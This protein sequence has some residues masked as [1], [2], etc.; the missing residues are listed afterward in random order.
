MK[1][2]NPLVIDN[3]DVEQGEYKETP[4]TEA[5]IALEDFLDKAK[6]VGATAKLTINKLSNGVNSSETFCSSYPVDKYDYFELLDVIQRSWGGGDY[7]I[8]CTVKG[9]KGVL[10]NQFISVG[11]PPIR[12]GHAQATGESGNVLQTVIK[13]MQENNERLIEALKP[14]E[15]TDAMNKALQQMLL[16]K[17]VLGNGGQKQSMLSSVKE[18]AEVMTL[19]QG[20][21][22][23]VEKESMLTSALNAFA[24]VAVAALQRPQA[25]QVRQYAQPRPVKTVNTPPQKPAPEPK[26]EVNPMDEHAAAIKQIITVLDTLGENGVA[27]SA[28]A[29][30]ITESIDTQEKFDALE[31]W[32]INPTCI[33][34][35]VKLDKNVERYQSWFLL[36]IEHVKAQMGLSSSVSD[37][38]EDEDEEDG[39]IPLEREYDFEAPVDSAPQIDNTKPHDDIQPI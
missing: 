17:Q 11:E 14:K 39:E 36:L 2:I 10:Q 38:Y 30:K 29:E 1:Q 23:G 12:I 3:D 15:D 16:M 31:M 20:L 19:M 22:G 6:A 37:E 24:P 25:Q 18:M 34:D 8:Y 35:L 33:D 4:K 7:R 27:P 28:I 21:G 13:M 32:V 9:R 5:D 26:K